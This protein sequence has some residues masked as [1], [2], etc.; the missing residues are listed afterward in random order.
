MKASDR[1]KIIGVLSGIGRNKGRKIRDFSLSSKG[2]RWYI[3]AHMGLLGKE[4]IATFR[5]PGKAMDAY[6]YLK[7]LV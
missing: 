5:D 6:V 3:Y 4:K 1:K 2:D 7:S